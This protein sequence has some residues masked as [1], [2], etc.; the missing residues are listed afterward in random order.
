MALIV[1][2]EAGEDGAA[3]AVFPAGE[4]E[5]LASGLSAFVTAHR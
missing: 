5:A 3:D 4:E 1:V 2:E